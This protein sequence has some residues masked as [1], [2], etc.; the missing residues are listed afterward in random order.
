MMLTSSLTGKKFLDNLSKAWYNVFTRLGKREPMDPDFFENYIK[1]QPAPYQTVRAQEIFRLDWFATLLTAVALPNTRVPVIA[2]GAVRDMFFG[3]P[4]ADYDI[5]MDLSPFT[6]DEKDDALLLTAMRFREAVGLTERDAPLYDK[7][8]GHY[9]QELGSFMVYECNTPNFTFQLIGHNNPLLTTNPKQFVEESFDWSLTKALYDPLH[10][11][12]E[13][14]D[15]FL[16]TLRTG[17]IKPK[18]DSSYNRAR[19]WLDWRHG[20]DRGLKI[21]YKHKEKGHGTTMSI[22]ELLKF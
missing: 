9:E 3:V 16:E 2:G 19:N 17:V 8:N 5:F 13:F 18:D 11:K 1:Q 22:D 4:P 21:E 7:H 12:P 6:E 10:G 15:E 14:C 20:Q